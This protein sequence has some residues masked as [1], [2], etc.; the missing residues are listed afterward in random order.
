MGHGIFEK[1]APAL[2][3]NAFFAFIAPFFVTL[4]VI[5]SLV[6][7]AKAD[8]E[9]IQVLVDEDIAKYRNSKIKSKVN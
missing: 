5:N 8:I 7:Y 1:R 4:E 2:L 9:K 6:G 3:T